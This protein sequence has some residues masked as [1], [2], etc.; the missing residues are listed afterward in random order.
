MG[1]DRQYMEDETLP[2]GHKVPLFETYDGGMVAI[3]NPPYSVTGTKMSGIV[4]CVEI[5]RPEC[6]WVK[7]DDEQYERIKAFKRDMQ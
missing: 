7:V 5:A 2:C 6:G 3:V 1:D 4:W